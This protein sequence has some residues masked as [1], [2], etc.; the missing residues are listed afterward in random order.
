MTNYTIPS[1]LFFLLLV[2][3]SIQLAHGSQSVTGTE[4]I[5]IY[6]PNNS[7][8]YL[9]SSNTNGGGTPKA[10]TM[11]A[12][13]DIPIVGD[14]NNNGV[15]T[16]GV[17]RPST[18]TFYLGSSNTNGGGTPKD[19]TM[20]AS[21]DKPIDGYWVNTNETIIKGDNSLKVGRNHIISG[22]GT[23]QNPYLISNLVIE[24]TPLS[25]DN[26][27][28]IT[29]TTKFVQI[30]NIDISGGMTG[31]FIKNATNITVDNVTISDTADGIGIAGSNNINIKNSQIYDLS[32][33]GI[34][35]ITSWHPELVYENSIVNCTIQNTGMHLIVVFGNDT[36]IQNNKLLDST[37]LP[38]GVFAPF[39]H[40][41]IDGNYIENAGLDS[42]YVMG[43]GHP[44][45]PSSGKTPAGSSQ[46]YIVNNELTNIHD[47]GIE[48]GWVSNGVISHN[49]IHDSPLATSQFNPGHINSIMLWKDTNSTEVTNNI[50]ANMGGDP[51][52]Y[53]DGILVVES[54]HNNINNNAITNVADHGI[55]FLWDDN[56]YQMPQQS[57]VIK[58]YVFQS[59]NVGYKNFFTQQNLTQANTVSFP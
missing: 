47:D 15:S 28:N 26:G 46:V 44:S 40:S 30:S 39:V 34:N 14:W 37:Y 20:G 36:L 52:K 18:N 12:S 8:F 11:G 9:A 23:Q 35:F 6:H 58:N 3:L 22:N 24:P 51:S 19:V 53:A 31:I 56:T 50:I 17:Y 57:N 4:P 1:L 59:P 32:D 48:I 25:N 49:Y 5:G 33:T 2:P 38:L 55:F 42:I 45:T 41:V 16:I 27:I 21:G 29:N 43:F 54:S 13:G 10:V 7:T